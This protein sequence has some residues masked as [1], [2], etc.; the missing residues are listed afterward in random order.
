MGKGRV[1]TPNPRAIAPWWTPIHWG[2]G[3]VRAHALPHRCIPPGSIGAQ[4]GLEGA[5]AAA[6]RRADGAGP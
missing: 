1:R 4:P 2:H 3:A 5:G 6:E